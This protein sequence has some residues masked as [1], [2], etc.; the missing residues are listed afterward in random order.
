MTA[1]VLPLPFVPATVIVVA[2]GDSN[3]NRSATSPQRAN[4]RSIAEG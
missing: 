3:P 4:P 2:E 1:T